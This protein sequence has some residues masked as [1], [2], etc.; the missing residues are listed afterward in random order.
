MEAAKKRPEAVEELELLDITDDVIELADAIIESGIIPQNS[1]TDAAHISVAAVHGMDFLMTWNCAHIDNAEVKPIV[2]NIC[3]SR[4]FDC[5]V[6]VHRRNLWEELIMWKDHIVEEIRKIRENNAAKLNF[7]IKAIV[8]DA[9][10]RQS[11][12][13]HKV[14]SFLKV[15]K[16]S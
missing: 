9:Q 7:D 13:K 3:K 6:I 5:P 10:K 12:S 1:P 14:V 16:T 4:G 8:K 15:S 2:A 11:I